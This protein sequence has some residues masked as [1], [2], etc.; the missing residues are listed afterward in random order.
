MYRF[1]HSIDY[2]NNVPKK[3]VTTKFVENYVL[4]M[5]KKPFQYYL[6]KQFF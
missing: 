5:R 1:E 4:K 3:Q 6:P 2:V